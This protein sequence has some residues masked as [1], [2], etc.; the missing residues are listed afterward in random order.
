MCH[1][2]NKVIS[3]IDNDFGDIMIMALRYA[4][5]RRTY[6]TSEVCD[7]IKQNIKHVNN[8]VRDVMIRDIE[9]YK[10]KREQGFIND[11]P[12]DEYNFTDLL[13][14]LEKV[15]EDFDEKET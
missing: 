8:R 15:G 4:L 13:V 10:S 14:S 2:K 12:C 3:D 7:F 1:F 5:G 9:E 6:V 11:D